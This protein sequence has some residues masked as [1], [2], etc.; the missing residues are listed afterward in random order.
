MKANVNG[1]I[2]WMHSGKHIY[3]ADSKF[4]SCNSNGDSVFALL[5]MDSPDLEKYAMINFD[6]ESGRII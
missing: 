6:Q 5:W 3:S 4:M 1:K 2:H